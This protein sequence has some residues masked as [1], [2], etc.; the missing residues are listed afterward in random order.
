MKDSL[1][2]RSLAV[3]SAT[4]LAVAIVV[5]ALSLG[6]AER[7][8]FRSNA[9]GLERAAQAA[10]AFLPADW[11]D[12]SGPEAAASG[13]SISERFSARYSA[14]L[15]AA[16]GYRVTLVDA[17]GKVLG[18]S[19]ADPASM[20][21]HSDRPEVA[22]AFKG[23][24]SWSRRLSATTGIWM[25]YAAVPVFRADGRTMAGVLRLALPLP[26]LLESLGDAKRSMILAA[27]AVA[28]AALAGSVLLIRILERP[29]VLLAERARKYAHG[30]PETDA[31]TAAGKNSAKAGLKSGKSMPSELKL[32]EESL[33]SMAAGL[34]R[35][36]AEAEALSRRYSAILDSAGEAILA[37]DDRLEV[38]EA[39]P[40]AHRLLG[41]EPGTLS[42]SLLPR[43]AGASALVAIA[44]RCI[45]S[46]TPTTDD[47]SLYPGS[48]RTVHVNASRLG[49]GENPGIVLAITD[50][51]V[52]KL[53]LIHI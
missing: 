19:G 10:S 43:I 25:L 39:N 15:G 9:E 50:I 23:R 21:N 7:A 36:A 30:A 4:V 8:Y 46:G 44:N 34:S 22:E 3:V 35:K 52:L 17:L 5:L 27:L 33:D 14:N 26:G 45:A 12:P 41:M 2:A 13:A 40:A 53:S 31:A 37:L 18:D 28:L 1:F 48:E 16:S 42:G 29:V 38:I 20:T 49:G 6:I 24:A 51:S 32:L 47:A 11:A